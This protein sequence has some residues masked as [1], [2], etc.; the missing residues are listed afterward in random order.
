M[1]YD[2]IAKS[3]PLWNGLSEKEKEIVSSISR[4]I[5]IG[6]ESVAK[7]FVIYGGSDKQATMDY[8]RKKYGF[9]ME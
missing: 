7:I 1:L 2:E 6:C 4:K 9:V 5:P 8:L 3:Y